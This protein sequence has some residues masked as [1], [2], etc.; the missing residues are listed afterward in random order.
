MPTEEEYAKKLVSLWP[1]VETARLLSRPVRKRRALRWGSELAAAVSFSRHL[2]C[3]GLGRG[4]FA[5]K[6]EMVLTRP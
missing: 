2:G 6:G 5:G 1:G 4:T 3:C